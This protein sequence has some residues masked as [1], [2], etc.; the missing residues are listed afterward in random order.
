M[1]F[2]VGKYYVTRDGRKA[3]V[4]CVNRLYSHPLVVLVTQS[5][6]KEIVWSYLLNG[7]AENDVESAGDLVGP[8]QEPFVRWAIFRN[9]GVCI[10]IYS[11]EQDARNYCKYK[12]EI[13]RVVKL[14]EEKGE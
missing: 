1:Q 4:I 7:R 13:Y 9:D 10:H 14:V 11:K 2:E 3:R 5:E 6:K 12:E 8:W